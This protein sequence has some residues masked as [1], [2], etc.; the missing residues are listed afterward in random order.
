MFVLVRKDLSKN[1]QA[2]QA[3]HAL[4]EYLMHVQQHNWTNGTLIYLGVDNEK[5]LEKWGEILDIH[6]IR[7]AKF[8]EPDRNN[9]MTA[10][11]AASDKNIFR[12]LQLLNMEIIH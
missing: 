10:I 3:G 1:Q 8:I 12:K 7:W 6:N 9:E 2:V 11:S 4:A 5:D